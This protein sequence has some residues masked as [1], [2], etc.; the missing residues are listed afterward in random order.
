MTTESSAKLM[1][2]I[3][4]ATEDELRARLLKIIQ[5]FLVSES[6]KHAAR[7]KGLFLVIARRDLR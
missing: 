2:D 1:D 4:V 7:E 5:D 6:A 3:F